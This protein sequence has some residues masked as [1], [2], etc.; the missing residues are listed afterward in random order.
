M[1]RSDKWRSSPLRDSQLLA[2]YRTSIV[3]ILITVQDPKTQIFKNEL[4]FEAIN[5]LKFDPLMRSSLWAL[6]LFKLLLDV[7]LFKVVLVINFDYSLVLFLMIF[8]AMPIGFSDPFLVQYL[9]LYDFAAGTFSH[10]ILT[11]SLP[12]EASFG[13][14][15][16]LMVL[17]FQ[18]SMWTFFLYSAMQSTTLFRL[19][20]VLESFDNH[21]NKN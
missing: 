11:Q 5:I 13:W 20:C 2:N 9:T 10:D 16:L 17:F 8:W 18:I 21:L 3:Q 6:D 1:P 12:R 4:N 14:N 15:I 7:D 19:L